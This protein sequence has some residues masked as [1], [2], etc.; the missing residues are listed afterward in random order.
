MQHNKRHDLV[1]KKFGKIT[2]L[3][4][5]DKKKN[6]LYLW[7]CLCECGNIC[8]DTSQNLETG[9]RKSCGC[10]LKKDL[11][12][13]KTG[14]LTVLSYEGIRSYDKTH[15][16]RLW[17]CL[18]DCGKH[19]VLS[20]AV[21]TKN[22][23]KSCGCLHELKGNKNKNWK[24]F[25][26]ISGCIWKQIK[27]NQKSR[28]L[29]FNITIEYIWDLYIKQNRKCSLTGLEINFGKSKTASLDRID[30]SKGYLVGNVQWVHK[31]INKMKTDFDQG[32]FITFCKLVANYG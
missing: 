5:S 27:A 18:C 7:E 10:L 4:V 16:E 25:E 13:I 20:T 17:K 1:G 23:V 6:R 26:E 22:K 24:G 3:K 14:M 32:E 30:S 19:T 21:L 31:N 9:H 29:D 11:I 12:G 28:N 15:S 2:V 8:Y